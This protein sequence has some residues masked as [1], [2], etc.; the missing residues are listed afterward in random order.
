MIFAAYSHSGKV[1]QDNQDSYAV[2]QADAETL[3]AVVADGMGGHKGG[4]V[5]SAMAVECIKTRIETDYRPQMTASELVL[6]MKKSFSEANTVIFE[7]SLKDKELFGMGT[8][9]TLAAVRRSEAV[10]THVGDSRAYLI[11]RGHMRQITTDHTLVQDLLDKGE[12]TAAQAKTHPQK[13]MI[14]QA[15]GTEGVVATD[16]YTISVKGQILLLCS[17]GLTNMVSDEEIAEVMNTSDDLNKG[18]LRLIDL[19]NTA[20]GEDNITIVAIRDEIR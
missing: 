8:T 12:I 2:F 19:A 3:F 14:M 16:T 11:G 10:I 15:L 5:A 4:S 6:L 20:G 18:I 1:R 13:H 7:R 9:A 17:D